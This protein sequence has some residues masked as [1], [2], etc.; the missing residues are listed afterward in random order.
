MIIG[1]GRIAAQGTLDELLA[2]SG[3]LVRAGER[4]RPSA[5]R[6]KTAGLAAQRLRDGGFI[7]DA[8]PEAVGRAAL[9]G[10]VALTHLG[11][12]EGSGLEQLFFE[13]TERQE[14]Q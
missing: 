2:G 9:A 6:S 13:L 1:E 11:P 10:G 4:T 7:V 12:S 14:S 8:E 5:A 3:T